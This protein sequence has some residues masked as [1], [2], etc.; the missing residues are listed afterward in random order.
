MGERDPDV[1]GRRAGGIGGVVVG[2]L[3]RLAFRA[4]PGEVMLYLAGDLVL[5]PAEHGCDETRD[6]G[7]ALISRS[8]VGC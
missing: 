4:E 8:N 1:R 7:G 6:L 2:L 3:L 5:G